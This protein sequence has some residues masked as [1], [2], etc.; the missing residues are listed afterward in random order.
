MDKINVR[1][2]IYLP[3]QVTLKDEAGDSI[4]TYTADNA[5]TCKVWSGDN[6][7][8]VATPSVAWIDPTL[9]TLLISFLADDTS[10]LLSG[11]YLCSVELALTGDLV[12]ETLEA[13]RA[14]LVV[15]DSPGTQVAPP[16]YCSYQDLLAFAPQIAKEKADSTQ[17][18]FAEQRGLAREWIERVILSKAGRYQGR[19]I[20]TLLD[21]DK[22][23]VTSQVK[24]IAVKKTLAL[25]FGTAFSPSKETTAYVDFASRMA[26]QANSEI[27]S[28]VA[29]FDLNND[30]VCDMIVNCGVMSMRADDCQHYWGIYNV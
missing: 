19:Y 23:L 30:G 2:G 17:T 25:I 3:W 5:L 27:V 6:T 29:E 1:Q 11:S 13:Y 12:G 14:D 4:T 26:Q 20:K 9:G 18:G 10:A 28:M 24:Q 21:E 16:S 22:L 7:A 15:E 8:T